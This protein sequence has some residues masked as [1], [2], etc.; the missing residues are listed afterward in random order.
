[1]FLEA[2][3]YD[4]TSRTL[5]TLRQE[6]PP[7][8]CWC[9]PRSGVMGLGHPWGDEED[10]VKG[11]WAPFFFGFGF[12]WRSLVFLGARS[13][14]LGQAGSGIVWLDWYP[15]GKLDSKT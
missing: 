2:L 14:V 6:G 4:A 8:P 5:L 1:M 11:T 7:E 12:C 10:G 13:E 3:L 15:Q 9:T